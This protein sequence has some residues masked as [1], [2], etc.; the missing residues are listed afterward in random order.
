MRRARLLDLGGGNDRRN[1]DTTSRNEEREAETK[2]PRRKLAP[3]YPAPR[4]ADSYTPE[5]TIH[6]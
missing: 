2:A 6:P 4:F 1:V 5:S 3:L